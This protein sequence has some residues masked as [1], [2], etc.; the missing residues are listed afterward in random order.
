VAGVQRDM[1]ARLGAWMSEVNVPPGALLDV[2][3]R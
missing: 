3:G 1:E 2:R